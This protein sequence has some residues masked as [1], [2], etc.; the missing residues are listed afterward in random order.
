MNHRR[1]GFL[2]ITSL[3]YYGLQFTHAQEIP[4]DWQIGTMDHVN[5][6]PESFFKSNVPDVVQLDY[7]KGSNKVPFYFCDNL[8]DYRNLEKSYWCYKTTFEKPNLKEDDHHVFISKG[9]DY[10]F[11]IILNDTL[12]LHQEGMFTPV[13][14]VLNEHMKDDAGVVLCSWPHNNQPVLP[15]VYAQEVWNGVEF[16]VAS[17]LI[18]V[19]MVDEGIEIAEAVDFKRIFVQAKTAGIRQIIVENEQWNG[20]LECAEVSFKS[21]KKL[22]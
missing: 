22:F 17:S 16:G 19:D 8:K 12:L 6:M 2:Y 13:K 9:I 21:L 15:F 3:I 1:I 7:M 14:F 11:D 18:H 5:E 20:G 10:E 4:L